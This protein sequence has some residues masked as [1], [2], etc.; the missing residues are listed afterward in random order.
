MRPEDA[1]AA[2][3]AGA[4]AIGINFYSKAKRCIDLATAQEII[5]RLPPFVTPVGLF[6]NAELGEIR[7]IA[8][9]LHLTHLQLHGAETPELVAQLNDYVIFKSIFA[10][11][12]TLAD[13]VI[14]WKSARA[15]HLRHLKGFVLETPHTGHAGG[16]GVENDWAMIAEFAR[17]GL[18]DGG[19]P[20]IAAGGLNPD[21]VGLVARSLRPW[22]V[23]VSSGVEE[24]F[25]QKSPAKI[26]DFV[27]AVRSADAS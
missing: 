15:R 2:A 7:S 26:R 3:E 6:V 4:D 22:A 24:A 14:Q 25:G 9:A 17:D 23:D 20:L 1:L 18:F 10:D 11:R 21:N 16:S 19:P 27:A 8:E 5:R 13:Q 12:A